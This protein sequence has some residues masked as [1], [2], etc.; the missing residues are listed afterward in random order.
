AAGTLSRMNHG[1]SSVAGAPDIGVGR[2]ARFALLLGGAGLTGGATF[3]SP[4]LHVISTAA[5]SVTTG[6]WNSTDTPE[7]HV[8]RLAYAA[9]RMTS[10]LPSLCPSAVAVSRARSTALP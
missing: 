8:S 2:G 4:A 9:H 1:T 7:W 10:N 5:P 6:E 3:S